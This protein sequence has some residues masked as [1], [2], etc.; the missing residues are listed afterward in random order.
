MSANKQ[1]RMLANM[2]ENIILSAEMRL[3]LNK[4]QDTVAE[5]RHDLDK[6]LLAKDSPKNYVISFYIDKEAADKIGTPVA[7]VGDDFLETLSFWYGSGNVTKEF[8][9]E[10]FDGMDWQRVV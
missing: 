6:L 5:I 3:D 7:D 8:Y 10:E 9:Q 4:V 2:L 1:L